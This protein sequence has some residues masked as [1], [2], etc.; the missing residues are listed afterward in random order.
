[1]AEIYRESSN[2]LIL[3][4]TQIQGLGLSVNDIGG[5]FLKE[6]LE[7]LLG[8]PDCVGIRI[9][10]SGEP[11]FDMDGFVIGENP[12][13]VAVAVKSDGFEINFGDVFY[14]SHNI[15]SGPPLTTRITPVD[16]DAARIIVN[17]DDVTAAQF[18]SF[19]S[20]KDLE[21]D[22]FNGAPDGIT[23]YLASL[24]VASP[25]DF[26]DHHLT[27]IKTNSSNFASHIAFRTN[28]INGNIPMSPDISRNVLSLYP[29]P[30]HCVNINDP[31]NL[32]NSAG[33]LEGALP[34]DPYLFEWQ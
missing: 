2:G 22:L 34:S 11:V 19:F 4:M 17:H 25:G 16:H 12:R 32:V 28:L 10:N 33:R 15:I 31:H 18:M 23:F 3:N 6:D 8:E 21:D 9:Y 26:T 20:K 14:V 30:G 7:V 13:L 29:C 1:M 24:G 27:P 5:F